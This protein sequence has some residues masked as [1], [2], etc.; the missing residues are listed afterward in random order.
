MKKTR[1]LILGIGG[2]GGYYG[3]KL[4]ARY[5]NSPEMEIVF[6]ARGAHA[7]VIR[8]N[9]LQ[10]FTTQGEFIA[11]PHL[12][13][14][15]A[16]MAGVADIFICA[17]K[18]YDLEESLKQYAS[19]IAPHTVVIPL[20]N[21]IDSAERIRALIPAAEVVDACVYIVSRLTNPG[22]IRETG[23]ISLV[24]FGNGN[25]HNERIK[26]ILR[27]FNK[28]GIE[29][30]SPPNI[31][32][33]AWEKF[34]FISSIASLTCYFNAPVGDILSDPDRKDMLLRMIM[35]LESVAAAKRVQLPPDVVE[36][37]MERLA[38]LPPETTSSMHTDLQKGGKTEV[39]ALT[40]YVVITARELGF[41]VPV[42][43][44]VL[45]GLIQPNR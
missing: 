32:Q 2:V 4:A 9:G 12:V 35:E 6:L 16:Q 24:F 31:L 17:V 34:L 25:P 1:I 29:A 44:K 37:V 22:I 39:D 23:K 28:A 15:D 10:V 11:R 19:C 5:A 3:G 43:E 21:G 8:Q 20:M 40:R 45:N 7:D 38:S 26:S 18:S 41:A 14:A 13:T 33:I 36:K 30:Q 42:F 27:L